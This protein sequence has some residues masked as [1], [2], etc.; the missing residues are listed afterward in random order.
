MQKNNKLERDICIINIYSVSAARADYPNYIALR[1]TLATSEEPVPYDWME[2]SVPGP[3][4]SCTKLLMSS[5]KRVSMY[6]TANAFGTLSVRVKPSRLCLSVLHRRFYRRLRPLCRDRC[7]GRSGKVKFGGFLYSPAKPA[8][9]IPDVFL[10]R[11][12]FRVA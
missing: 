12:S 5:P 8:S 7:S 10:E 4:C 2:I 6:S 3:N 11:H 1:C 9:A